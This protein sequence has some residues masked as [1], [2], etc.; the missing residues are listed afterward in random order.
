M[1]TFESLH[2]EAK[3]ACGAR[4]FTITVLDR[5][6]GVAW[7]AYSSHPG[8]YPVTGTKPLQE[9]D[10]T[11]QVLN[12]AE[13]FV[14]NTTSEFAPYFA[15]HAVI[16][17]LDCEAAVN[18]PVSDGKVVQGTVNILDKEG[19]FTPDRVAAL[20]RLV[21]ENRTGLLRAFETIL[22]DTDR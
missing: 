10:W 19:H 13:T 22:Q 17:A 1:K 12:R 2:A 18:I 11:R 8:D 21:A 7:R 4:L 14:A 20:E 16:N 6:A 3:A 15:D 9:N 5:K